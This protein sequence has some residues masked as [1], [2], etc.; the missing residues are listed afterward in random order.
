M[1]V[2]E[3]A[4][5]GTDPVAV[6]V[7]PRDAASTLPAHCYVIAE[8]SASRVARRADITMAKA[9][10][11][12]VH[13]LALVRKPHYRVLDNPPAVLGPDGRLDCAAP[14]VTPHHPRFVTHLFVSA[15][16]VEPCPIAHG[17]TRRAPPQCHAPPSR[18]RVTHVKVRPPIDKDPEL[19]LQ[20]LEHGVLMQC[21]PA[22]AVGG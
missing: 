1:R 17:A 20:C 4:D 12:R 6:V 13:A 21:T 19:L 10:R 14:A 8:Q 7:I 3:A 9:V 5:A 11:L 22:P 2:V 18:Q 16:S 15:T